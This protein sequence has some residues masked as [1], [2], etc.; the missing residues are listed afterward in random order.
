[1]E[2]RESLKAKNEEGDA[3]ISEIEVSHHIIYAYRC[4]SDL[5]VLRS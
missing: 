5:H 1:M 3:Y 2:L 4:Q